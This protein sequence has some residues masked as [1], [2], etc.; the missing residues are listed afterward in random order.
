MLFRM[1]IC[2]YFTF[3]IFALHCD[4]WNFQNSPKVWYSVILSKLLLEFAILDLPLVSRVAGFRN[5][6]VWSLSFWVPSHLKSVKSKKKYCSFN[7]LYFVFF[8]VNFQ[9][10]PLDGYSKYVYAGCDLFSGHIYYWTWPLNWNRKFTE[11]FPG[12]LNFHHSQPKLKTDQ[13]SCKII[14]CSTIIL[15]FHEFDCWKKSR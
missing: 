12:T 11:L 7:M 14:S 1:K 4:L 8:V 5:T 2:G 13:Q 15:I 10:P 6:W 9:F 3:W